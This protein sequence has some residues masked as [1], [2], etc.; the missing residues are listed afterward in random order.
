MNCTVCGVK[1]ADSN[2]T[3][4]PVCIL[5]AGEAGAYV[6]SPAI[7][8]ATDRWRGQTAVYVSPKVGRAQS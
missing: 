7:D 5:T 8:R 6:S 4:C 2:R 3:V 1:I